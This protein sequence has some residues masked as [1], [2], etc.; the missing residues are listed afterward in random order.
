VSVAVILVAAGVGRRLADDGQP[1]AL[2]ALAGRPLLR[3]ALVRLRQA[4]PGPIVVVH[5]PG[6]Q[7]SFADAVAEVTDVV[8]VRGGE[9][10]TASVRAGMAA[11]PANCDVVAVHDAA[12]ALTPPA[13]IAATIAAVAGRVVAA[14]PG[15]PVA[16]TLKTVEDGR[17][18]GTVSRD[19]VW[20]IQTPQVFARVTLE[21]AHR[22]AGDESA[23]DDLGLVEAAR[24]AGAVAGDIAVV[25]GSV[26]GLKIT[27]AED[28][29]V[30]DAL[31]RVGEV[32]A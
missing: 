2:V 4:T 14:A 13:V 21:T 11:L 20:A 9:T 28:L 6:H 12:R 18:L 27:Y 22:W 8:L 26:Q 10:R 1:K 16:D 25:P 19:R 31:L 32:R 29:E 15:L 24:D 17:V 3:H 7:Q 30:A 23:T 5:T